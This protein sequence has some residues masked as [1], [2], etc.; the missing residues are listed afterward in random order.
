MA[1]ATAGSV[2]ASASACTA[3]H[4]HAAAAGRLDDLHADFN[5]ARP[6]CAGACATTAACKRKKTRPGF[7]WVVGIAA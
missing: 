5:A 3:L 6:G 7:T 2:V 1:V 4:T